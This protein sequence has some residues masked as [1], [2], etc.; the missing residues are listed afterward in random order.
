MY[1]FINIG[2]LAVRMAVAMLIGL[3]V[4][5]E[6]SYN[7]NFQNHDSIAHVHNHTIEPLEKKADYSTSMQQ[8]LATVLREK[9]GHIFKHVILL[10]WESDYSI[11]IG[12]NNVVKTG[13]FFSEGVLDMFSLK[14]LKGSKE[15]LKDMHGIVISETTSISLFGEKDP[16]GEIVKLN[17]K[18]NCKITGVYEDIAKN[19]FLG[20]IQ[21]IG[22]FE[23]IK[24]TFPKIKANE[25]NWHNSSQRLFVQ[26]ADNVSMEQ[27]NAAIKDFYLKDAPDDFKALAKEYQAI[28]YLNPMKNWHLYSEYKDG[29]PSG[30][31]IT[32][33]W[34]FSIVGLFVLFLACINFMNL[35]TARSEKRA[36]EVGIRKAIGSLKS[37]L[38]NQFLIESFLVVLIAFFITLGLV[39]VFISTFNELAD[40]QITFP[41]SNLF[42]WIIC[43]TFLFFTSLF[44][45]LYP[46]FYLSSFE[47]VKVLKGT[48]RLGKY[49]SLPRKALVVVQFT[50]SIVLVI[51]TVIVYQQLQFA[52]NRPIG[53]DK[54]NLVRIPMS[55]PNF[56]NNK[57]IMKEEILRSGVAEK[58][59][60]SSS[61]VTAIWDNW[62]GFTWKG[63]D[64]KSE[65]SFAVTYI[66]EDYGSTIKWKI[67]RGRDFSSE[68]STDSAAVIINESA[69][70]YIG[71]QNPIGEFITNDDTK[72]KMQIIAVVEDVIADSPY[73]PV[74]MAFYWY[75]K[76]PNDLSE[77]LIKVNPRV[78]AK[79]ALFKIEGIQKNLVPSAP[80]QYKFTNEEYDLKFKA[81][82]RIGKLATFFAVFAIFI[83]YLGLFGL[84]SF[85]AE[86]RTKEF[87]IRKVLGATV[88]NLLQMLSK[89]FLILVI[90]ACLI[91]APTA[92]YFMHEWLQKY[93]YRTE[94]SW[95][96]FAGAAAGALFITLFTVSYQ[97][98]KAAVMN[99]VKALKTE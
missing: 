77:M 19:S 58:I 24:A 21:F 25:S 70:R 88:A 74:K 12:D 26:T 62:G 18:I 10:Q 16:I 66:N 1:S 7:R 2:G 57:Q 46:A 38:I 89:D 64:P 69:A 11:K 20:D 14:M 93:T 83:S 23:N 76:N 41:Y 87:G 91:A 68:F 96:I 42:F 60:F 30:G 90:V 13:Q 37:Q 65:S 97:A 54:E 4:W 72:Q 5:D 40:K 86:Q 35:S 56:N 55:D 50:V 71:L 27:A 82:Q 61:P 39:S 3:W 95:W 85:V 43:G 17:N 53:Y 73:D 51:G 45:G 49:A 75:I 36:R 98:I 84:A 52:Q 48:I 63:K 78:T 34:L 31:R 94:I 22:N 6:V 32:Y 59:A 47:P 15:S 44:S 28:L 29:Y 92:Y 80:F 81:E 99:P 9:Y 67:K 33:V 79:E 8:P